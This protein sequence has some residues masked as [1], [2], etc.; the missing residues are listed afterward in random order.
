MESQHQ[1]QNEPMRRA[2]E[3]NVCHGIPLSDRRQIDL[4]MR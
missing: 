1:E 2:A 3:P 4:R